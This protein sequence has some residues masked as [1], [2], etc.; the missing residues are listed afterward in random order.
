TRVPVGTAPADR[1]RTTKGAGDWS[2][3]PFARARLLLAPLVPVRPGRVEGR[4]LGVLL[5]RCGRLLLATGPG[6]PDRGSRAALAGDLRQ[7]L[8]HEQRRQRRGV[9]TARVGVHDDRSRGV[10][11]ERGADVEATLGQ[12]VLQDRTVV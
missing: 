3:T 7:Q 2:P 4:L 8:R 6:L 11:G 9:P 5:H 10:L 1:M 12:L